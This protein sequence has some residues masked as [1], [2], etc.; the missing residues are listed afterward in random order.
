MFIKSRLE[1]DGPQP[2]ERTGCTES[3]NGLMHY[4]LDL[5]AGFIFNLWLC[6]KCTNRFKELGGESKGLSR[7]R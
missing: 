6:E 7:I 3:L 2:C 5:G 4:T 1:T